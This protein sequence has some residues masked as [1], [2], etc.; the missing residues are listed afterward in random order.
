MSEKTAKERKEARQERAR[1]QTKEVVGK[2]GDFLTQIY[3]DVKIG[4]NVDQAYLDAFDWLMANQDM[5]LKEFS[6]DIDSFLIDNIDKPIGEFFESTGK[7]IVEQFRKDEDGR[8]GWEKS[9]V[10]AFKDFGASFLQRVKDK[11]LGPDLAAG[12]AEFEN[13]LDTRI[14]NLQALINSA[15]PDEVSELPAWQLELDTLRGRL[16][17][18]PDSGDVEE[19]ATWMAG[20]DA[21]PDGLRVTDTFSVRGEEKEILEKAI[22]NTEAE[23]PRLGDVN[24]ER[25]AANLKKEGE[26]AAKKRQGSGRTVN[27]ADA[28]ILGTAPESDLGSKER[29]LLDSYGTSR[30]EKRQQE[31]DRASLADRMRRERDP[32]YQ[33]DPNYEGELPFA[34]TDIEGNPDTSGDGDTG[35]NSQTDGTTRGSEL[36]PAAME[37]INENF[38]SVE[39]FQK[40]HGDKMWID[41]DGDGTLDTNVIQKIITDEEEN[42]DVIWGLFQKTQWFQENGPTARQFQMDWAKAAGSLATDWSPSFNP[43]AGI[44]QEWNMN[45]GMSELLDDTYDSLILEAERIG[46]NTDEVGTKNSIMQ[47]AYNAKQL[48]MSDYE[49]KNEFIT[50]VNLAFD[51]NAVKNSGTFGAI[52]NKLKSNAATYMIK[53]DDASLD[54]FAQDIYLGKGTYDGLNANFAQQAREENPAIASLIDQG[55]TPSA[56]FSSYGNVAS[57]LLGRPIDFMGGDSKMFSAL[58]N[59]MIGENNL[60]RPMTRGE[61]ERYVR[62][63]PEWDTSENARDEAYGTVGTLLSSF[64]IKV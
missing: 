33:A 63:T 7:K 62:A 22:E 30:E 46:I 43:N 47:M 16:A 58:T 12:A 35:D 3:D 38:G 41:T 53:L 36:T 32:S 45:A 42:P 28:A 8:F 10:K 55:Y 5:N 24:P 64:G 4:G 6:D 21:M 15:T 50:N 48:N 49:L 25:L 23:G 9:L 59:T 11:N 19:L 56:Y 60:G 27:P 37:Y 51:P 14:N 31:I 2:A 13:E 20:T 57:N 26:A 29:E 61:F 18:M 44:G 34:G 40:F 39:F 1:E 17:T 52:R 54:Q